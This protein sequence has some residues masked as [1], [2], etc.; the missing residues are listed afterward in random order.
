MAYARLLAVFAALGFALTGCTRPPARLSAVPS[1]AGDWRAASGG[2]VLDVSLGVRGT[3]VDGQGELH[4]PLGRNSYWLLTGE[5]NPP[6][7]VL[8]FVSH[9][10]VLGRYVG[11]LD[12]AGIMRG[13]LSD[14]GIPGDSLFFFRVH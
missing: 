13:V 5:Y 3:Y 7:I 10:R 6:R 9:D 8:R 11:Y 2:M 14:L 12:A 1:I 4:N